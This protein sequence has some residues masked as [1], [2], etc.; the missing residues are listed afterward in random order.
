MKTLPYFS[1]LLFCTSCG[2]R[3]NKSQAPEAPIT[4]GKATGA[5]P[6][7]RR[8]EE[9]QSLT[10]TMHLVSSGLNEVLKA[11]NSSPLGVAL[12]K[13]E[14]C[15]LTIKQQ[16]CSCIVVFRNA[17]PGK[18]SCLS[19]FSRAVENGEERNLTKATVVLEW[20]IAVEVI[21]SLRG[22]AG[23]EPVI[24]EDEAVL[25]EGPGNASILGLE[26]FNDSCVQNLLLIGL[27][28]NDDVR[29]VV[30]DIP[31]RSKIREH[32]GRLLDLVP[33]KDLAPEE[34]RFLQLLTNPAR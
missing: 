3:S 25:A 29:R 15:R 13:E 2:P 23:G 31:N 4:N 27:E 28:D 22:V 20:N 34:A 21:A 1:L 17:E 10:M 7:Q 14:M 16:K 30:P 33:K 12:S 26:F 8:I 11:S 5:E 19:I 9:N 24:T 6:Q 32:L 18:I